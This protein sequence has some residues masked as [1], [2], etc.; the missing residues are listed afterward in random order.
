MPR[1]TGSKFVLDVEVEENAENQAHYLLMGA[2][3]QSVTLPFL[4]AEYHIG[5]PTVTLPLGVSNSEGSLDTCFRF[6]PVNALIGLPLV[7]QAVA[8]DPTQSGPLLAVALTNGNITSIPANPTGPAAIV[9]YLYS[10][11]DPDDARIAEF[12]PRPGGIIIV[13]NE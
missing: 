3:Q 6:N 7:L 1:N 11:S 5:G 13:T 2:Q 12:G 4:C 10:K 8:V 9:A